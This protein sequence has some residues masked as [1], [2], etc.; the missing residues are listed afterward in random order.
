MCILEQKTI[1]A[2]SDLDP[3]FFILIQY[4]I[5]FK[6]ENELF[7][8]EDE[9]EYEGQIENHDKGKISDNV[10]EE[11]KDKFANIESYLNRIYRLKSFSEISSI[12]ILVVGCLVLIGWALDIPMLKSPSPGFST[13]KSNVGLCFILIGISLWFLQTK[14]T[15]KWMRRIAQVCAVVVALIGFLTLIEYLLNINLFID[16][17]LFKEPAGAIYTSS[18]NRM[19]FTAALNLFMAGI[20]LIL[21][22]RET[23]RSIKLSQILA[24]LL[25]SISLLAL[26]G[27]LYG[28]SALYYISQY[29]GI[30]V[31]AAITLFLIDVGILFARPDQG[32]MSIVTSE[33]LGGQ[34]AR[35]FLPVFIIVPILLGLIGI[36]GE[37][38]GLY[39]PNFG[40]SLIV[41]SGVVLFTLIIWWGAHSLNGIDIRRKKA[42][43]EL[44]E[45]KDHLE[46]LIEKRTNQLETLNINLQKEIEEHKKSKERISRLNSVLSSIRNINQ[47]IVT[48]KDEKTLLNEACKILTKTRG[49]KL[50]WIGRIEEGTF[51]VIP[52]AST[53]FGEDYLNSVKITYDDSPLGQGPSGTAIKTR[54]PSVVF[55]IASDPRYKPWREQALERG[56]ASSVA[57]PVMM[58]EEIYGT[59]NIYSDRLDVFDHEEVSLLEEL[60]VD[61]G[62]GIFSI[63]KELEREKIEKTLKISESYYRTI[64]ENTGTATVIVEEDS[65]ISLANTK[66]EKL[67]GFSKE[68]I[69]GKKS[70][71]EFVVKEDLEMMKK[72]HQQ[73]RVAPKGTP[74]QYEFHFID[75]QGVVKDIFLTVDMIPGTKK[76]I[77]SLLDITEFKKADESLKR[78]LKEKEVLL[79]EIHH[80]VKNNM[81]IISSLLNL[82]AGY[83]QDEKD[84]EVFKESQNRVKS[85][86]MIHEKLYQSE[87]LSE[88]DVGDYIKTLVS[89]LS[90]SYNA[91]P[92]KINTEFHIEKIK[93]NIETTIPLG[94]IINELITNSLKHAFP[95]DRKG[96]ISITLCSVNNQLSLTVADD[97]VG[98][99][100]DIDFQDT[101][102]LGLQL[103]NNLVGQLNGIIELDRSKGTEFRIIFEQ[104]KYKKRI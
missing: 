100:E 52:V 19:A 54:K 41:L 42:E 1:L 5:P 77:A 68:E 58:D 12:V 43:D 28:V 74:T 53:G 91:D 25:G 45:Y 101:Q 7:E 38:A 63:Y 31:Y 37:E 4:L 3:D 78:S 86:A 26:I 51:D 73:R 14:R 85:M 67:S 103:V 98:L 84:L 66:F 93:L 59:L 97:G 102:T 95:E 80:R 69:E 29:T 81:Q 96:T 92:R 46:D 36:W 20:A 16:Q 9:N 21:L 60:G 13:I 104:L 61:I 39:G 64:F 83:V 34:L 6:I 2:V 56:Y 40:E 50:V 76:S 65:T 32:L 75:G 33:N 47:L 55:D 8:M 24:C 79:Q 30:A 44:V 90:H 87:E 11:P 70:W 72:H 17:M 22:D 23:T 15:D 18:P 82:Q 71:T 57:V 10:N 27:F 48:E 49:Y 88:I 89:D 62:F 35:W 99:P 94:L